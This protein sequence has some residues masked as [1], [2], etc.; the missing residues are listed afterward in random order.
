LLDNADTVWYARRTQQG[1]IG[2]THDFNYVWYMVRDLRATSSTIDKQGIIED[3]CNHNS[4]AASFA[5]KILLYTYHP[6]W[7]Y[8]VTSDN[9]K[10]KNSLRGKSYKNFFGLLDDLKSR[11][12]TGHDAIGAVHTFIDSQSNKNNIEELIHCIIDKDLKTRAGDKIINKAIPDHIPEF[13]VALADKYEPKL[14]DW[15]EDWY[16]S[17]KIDGARCIAIVDENGDASFFSR[18]G[19]PFDTLDIVAGGIKAL[20]ITNVVFDGELCL[21]DDDG[22]EDFQGVMKELRKKDHTI[23]NP[24]YKI[25]DMVTTDEFYS[26]KGSKNRPYSIRYA[27]LCAIMQP[28]ECPCLTVL[29]QEVIKN[30]DHFNE[31]IA[32][33]TKE[34]WEG[35]MLRADEPYKGKR[36]KDLLKYKSFFDDE[37]QVVNAEMGPFRYVK[38]NAEFEETML[39]C[40]MI[41]HKGYTVRVGSGFS[42]EQ[43]QEFYKNPEKILGKIITVQYFEETKNQDGGIS[44]R[45]PTFKILHGSARTV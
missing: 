31:W 8:N 22:N 30:D 37:Y 9:L 4:E 35:L 6:L 5:K 23:P 18:T 11:K 29:E 42:I 10:K 3:Y 32:K 7:Q 28:N 14:V 26:K 21:V 34:K 40:V 24:S 39:S 38:D 43:R 45:F 16:V 41:N 44:L 13:S 1:E 17:R 36:S 20:G 27:N 2:M 33:S 12:I 19:K 25:F 15:K